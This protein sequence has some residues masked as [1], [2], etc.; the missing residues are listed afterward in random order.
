MPE[1]P[2]LRKASKILEW[3]WRGLERM[4]ATRKGLRPHVRPFILQRK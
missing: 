4:P 1:K 2:E 3:L